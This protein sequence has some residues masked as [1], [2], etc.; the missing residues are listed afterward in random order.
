MRARSR[1]PSA[2]SP[3]AAREAMRS[4]KSL[5]HSRKG[6]VA[7]EFVLVAPVLLMLLFGILMI[8]ILLENYLVLTA[9][10]QQGA[11]TLSLGAAQPLPIRPP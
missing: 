11:Q 9:P 10:A 1:R 5:V 7:L 6:V 3:F 4:I 8:G 2:E